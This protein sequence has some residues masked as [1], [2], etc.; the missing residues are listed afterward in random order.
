MSLA[1]SII[2]PIYNRPK[3]VSELLESIHRLDKKP[4][5]VI[6]VEDGSTVPCEEIAKAWELRLPI[7]YLY[8]KNSGPGSSRNFGAEYATGEY[9]IFLDSDCLLPQTYFNVLDRY[10]HLDAVDLFGGPD[11]AHKDFT[12]VQKAISQTMTGF[13]TT[14][15]IRGGGEGMDRFYPRSFNMGVKREVFFDLGGFGSL[16]FGE[17]LDFSMRAVK[18]GYR[19]ARFPEAWVY[20]KR[21]ATFRQFF[22]QVYNSGMARVY[23]YHLH[24]GTIKLVHVLPSVFVIGSLILLFLTFI[25]HWAFVLPL[26]IYAVMLYAE[27]VFRT[28]NTLVSLLSIPAGVIQLSGYGLGFI[29]AWFLSLLRKGGQRHAFQKNFYK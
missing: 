5:E 10:L 27:A 22:K 20:H 24:P 15:G 4:Q 29:H 8:K 17:D 28:K 9:L 19:V 26:F 6:L 25:W 2:V 11:A 16:R 14:G 3:E 18:A 21:R 13:F 23:L 1:Y 7:K 12:S